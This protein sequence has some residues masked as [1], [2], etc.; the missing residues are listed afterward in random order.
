[1][2]QALLLEADT[3]QQPVDPGV[4]L[5]A[6]RRHP[7]AVQLLER[8]PGHHGD[9][10][11]GRP[12]RAV[13]REGDLDVRPGLVEVGHHGGDLALANHREGALHAL[14]CFSRQSLLEP[15]DQGVGLR[16]WLGYVD[17]QGY[18]SASA[19]S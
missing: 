16:P 4:G 12:S 19:V 9:N 17:A 5:P 6:D 14:Q 2:V 11:A 7:S 3:L 15:G 1:M 18:S 8:K 10:V 13:G